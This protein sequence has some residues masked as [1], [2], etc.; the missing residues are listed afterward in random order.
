[1]A[2]RSNQIKRFTSKGT[3]APYSSRG[4]VQKANLGYF[5]TATGKVYHPGR[6]RADQGLTGSSVRTTN[7]AGGLRARTRKTPSLGMGSVSQYN[8]V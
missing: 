5:D 7:P 1:M 4:G 2:R 6:S 3:A 8:Q